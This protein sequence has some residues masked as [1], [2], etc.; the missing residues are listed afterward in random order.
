MSND[1]LK[2]IIEAKKEQIKQS[3]KAMPFAEAKKIAESRN[4]EK[5]FCE[6]LS[7]DFDAINIIAEIKRASPSKGDIS[8]N[9]D[10]AATAAAYE[11]AGASAISVLTEPDYFKGTI[12]DLK[13]V[14]RAVGIPVL[15][16]D[17]IISEYQIYESAAIEADAILLIVRC[18]ELS[19]LKDYMKLADSLGLDCL[20]EVYSKEDVS[21]AIAAEATLVGINNRNLKDF[22]TDIRNAMKLTSA[23]K[24]Y[25]I[26]VAASGI[27]GPADIEISK[28][29][30]ISNFLVGE[31]IVRSGDVEKFIRTLKGTLR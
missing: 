21:K 11:R 19:Q 14:K 10:A 7:R 4:A 6:S 24:G 16:K 13:A 31:S 17:F 1:F 20:V 2:I 18:L 15:R 30:G 22:N 9:L 26:P 28:V 5:R 23:L 8:P 25:Q 12:E 29:Y 27:E 3:Q